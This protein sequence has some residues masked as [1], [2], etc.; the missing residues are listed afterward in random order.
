MLKNYLGVKSLWLKKAATIELLKNDQPVPA[1][2]L[3]VLAAD[4]SVRYSLYSDLKEIKKQPLFP[5]QYFTQAY[6]AEAAMYN[7]ATDEDD[8]NY[9][10]MAF[11][12]KRTA[13]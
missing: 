9:S 7:E 2:V 11:V 12:N 3:N 10:S 6:F 1:A 8:D 5:A 13:M 4:K